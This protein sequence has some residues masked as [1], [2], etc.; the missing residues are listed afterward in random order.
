[1]TTTLQDIAERAGVTRMTVS[2]YLRTPDKVAAQTGERIAR[3]MAE[4]NYDPQ[5]PVAMPGHAPGR[6]L[7]V[8]IPSF[9]NQIFADLLSGIEQATRASHCQTLIANYNYDPLA[10]RSWYVTCFPGILTALS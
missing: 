1:M 2:R 8:L 3:A 4:L 5:R 9:K 10:K 6:T 7:G